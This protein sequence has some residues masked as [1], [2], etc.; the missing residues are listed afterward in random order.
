V[1]NDP[2]YQRR[3]DRLDQLSPLSPRQLGVSLHASHQPRQP[4]V[5]LE[6]RAE[7]EQLLDRVARAV[8]GVELDLRQALGRMSNDK[9]SI[10]A[11]RKD[12]AGEGDRVAYGWSRASSDAEIA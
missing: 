10:G 5:G 7:A 11:E 6:Q 9:M 8:A 2:H 3:R 12:G 4:F 1:G